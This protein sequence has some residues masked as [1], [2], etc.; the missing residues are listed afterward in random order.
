LADQ[1]VKLFRLDTSQSASFEKL[2]STGLD[3]SMFIGTPPMFASFEVGNP[4][5]ARAPVELR[6]RP[7]DVPADWSYWLS[8]P[9]P[10]LDPG[11]TTN[12]LLRMDP[13][14]D[15]L[16]GRVVRIG[17]EGFINDTYIGGV[18]VERRVP[19]FDF[20]VRLPIMSSQ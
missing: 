3:T 15:M 18:Y 13:N 10:V 1:G 20:K 4:T 7:V 17:V 14:G 6:I 5:D 11:Q 12:V 2:S 9:A 19:E 8:D 16:R